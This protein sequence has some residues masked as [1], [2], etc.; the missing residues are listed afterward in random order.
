M[1]EATL[2]R[3]IGNLD[4]E[5]LI[6][7]IG[8]L[9]NASEEAGQELLDYCQKY[10]TEENKNFVIEKQLKQHWKK[11][12][13]IIQSSN[14]YGGCSES[15]EN[16][17]YYEMS[18]MDDLLEKK[19]GITWEVR[20]EIL[21]ELLE[22]VAEDNSGFT[23]YIVDLALNMCYAKEEVI[24][25]AD[26]L[27][28]HG[29]SYYKNLAS[30]IYREV[31]EGQKYLASK[32]AQLKYGSDYLDLASYYE[33]QGK[34]EIA[35]QIVL[36]GLKKVD[37]RLDE[38][39]E[40]LYKFYKSKNDE[41]AIIALY[42]TALSKKKSI[43]YI[44][45]LLYEYYKEKRDYSKHKDMLLNLVQCSGSRDVKKWYTRC[46]EELLEHDFIKIEKS[47]L[48]IIK[49]KNLSVYYDICMEK[50]KTEEVLVYLKEHQQCNSWY[51]LDDNHRY[52][53]VLADEY[54][55]EIV[56]LYWKEVKHY[57]SLG[58]KANYR[59]AVSILRKIRQIMEKN[60]WTEDWNKQ[61]QQFINENRRKRLLIEELEKL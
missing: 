8:V 46:K 42:Q 10:A 34:Q 44:T 29:N 61:Y 31:G 27:I 16:D 58:K 24:Y 17:A 41:A 3:L 25:L 45:E 11:A 52:S 7:V 57:T 43:D 9:V 39:Y 50:G 19:N 55:Q 32:K 26:F 2:K 54:P 59:R 36:E 18:I 60:K 22:C 14:M 40:Y 56:E 38:I 6:K 1:D 4:K 21:D 5:E 51:G 48:G 12:Y 15:E 33:E 47:I 35:L 23:D 37:G 49:E 13:P 53:K 20:K 28:V 30:S